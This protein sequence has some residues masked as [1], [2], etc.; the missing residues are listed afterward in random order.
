MKRLPLGFGLLLRILPIEFRDRHRE[1]MLDLM[2]VYNEARSTPS[3][4]FFWFRAALDVVRVGPS[5]RFGR[6]PHTFEAQRKVLRPNPLESVVQDVRYSFRGLKRDLGLSALAVLIVGLGI[7]ASSTV[8]SVGNA[9]LV[10]PLP[11]E[12]PERLV[13]ISNGDWG[14]GQA[15]SSITT[16][17]F[18]LWD[19]QNE[20]RTF[21]DVAGY[22]LFDWAGDHTLTGSGEPERLTR[23]RVTGNLFPLLGVQPMIGR[24]FTPEEAQEYGPGAIILS[25]GLWLRR[26]GADP[27]IVG[28]SLTLNGNPVH[29]V[30]VLPA[31]FDFNSIFPHDNRIDF[32]APFPLTERTNRQGNTLALIGRIQPGATIEAAQAEASLI[33]EREWDGEGWTNDF[34]P[35]LGPLREH[36]SGGFRPAV[37][38]LG[39]AVTLVMLIVCANLSNL[40]LARGAGREREIAIR[41]ALGG[42]RARLVRQMLTESGMLALLGGALGLLVALAGTNTLASLDVNI[43]LLDRVR[44]DGS[45]LAF[46][47]VA[48]VAAGLVFGLTPAVRL[49]AVSLNESLKE[50]GRSFSF[51]KRFGWTRNALVVAEVALAC[52]LL[53]GAG[54]RVQRHIGA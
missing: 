42:T 45:V 5:L 34:E 10:R 33:A 50:G 46:N 9:L 47:I 3:R 52:V 7:G 43:Q 41:A 51:G 25:H 29:V 19:L 32:V 20:S 24:F 8:F 22:C 15:L 53:V 28:R 6:S 13:W 44:V 14:R 54:S 35:V 37:L 49:S 48:A 2:A 16:Q 12:E 11:F 4:C 38:L 17:V 30:G 18:R 36:V 40:L 23:L 26:F 1:E 31:S 21:E 27:E 39:G